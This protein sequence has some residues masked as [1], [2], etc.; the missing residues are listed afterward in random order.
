M[1]TTTP[2]TVRLTRDD[3][4]WT[5]FRFDAFFDDCRQFVN[6]NGRCL[7]DNDFSML[8]RGRMADVFSERHVRTTR[9]AIV[10]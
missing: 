9:A 4:L 7:F 5:G 8:R 3:N 1:I 10:E 2:I 6:L